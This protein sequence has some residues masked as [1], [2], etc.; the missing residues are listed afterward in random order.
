LVPPP[1]LTYQRRSTEDSAIPALTPEYP[2]NTYAAY[3]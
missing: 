3:R 1:D 2:A